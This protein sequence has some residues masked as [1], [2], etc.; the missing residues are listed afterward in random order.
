MAEPQI[1]V[2]DEEQLKIRK[3]E[4]AH[5]TNYK[6]TTPS[7]NGS[8]EVGP[9]PL[10]RAK[11]GKSAVRTFKETFRE[12]HRN[13]LLHP[14]IY[15]RDDESQSCLQDFRIKAIE[16]FIRGVKTTAP[17]P[18]IEQTPSVWVHDRSWNPSP[19]SSREINHE[20][21]YPENFLQTL[22]SEVSLLPLLAGDCIS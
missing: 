21:S 14:F 7:E 9:V 11:G 22:K 16:D 19:S 5:M 18:D 15:Q 4:A 13:D 3:P 6:V 20:I 8:L 12:T 10:A 17:N 2:I 1:E